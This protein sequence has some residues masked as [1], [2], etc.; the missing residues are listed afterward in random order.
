MMKTVRESDT[1]ARWGG[2]EFVVIAPETS[3]KDACKLAERIRLA[4]EGHDFPH[5][6]R[7]PLGL[8][9]LSIGIA[10]RSRETESAE[11]LLR[12]AD[13]ATYAAKD[14]GRNRCILYAG[15]EDMKLVASTSK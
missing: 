8:V 11:K 7:Q 2:E 15:K 3:A 1:L 12:F 6:E 14:R 9:S 10:A 5:A 13:D 4:V